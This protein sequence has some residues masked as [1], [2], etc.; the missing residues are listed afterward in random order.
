MR[1][2]EKI[3]KVVKDTVAPE[4]EPVRILDV[5][6]FL[7]HDADGDEIIWVKI[8]YDGETNNFDPKKTIGIVRKLRPKLL[9]SANESAFPVISY[10]SSTDNG[11]DY[12]AAA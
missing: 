10:I 11:R 1:D 3:A 4:I 12:F 5:R 6:A 9:S 2:F 7:G 8:L